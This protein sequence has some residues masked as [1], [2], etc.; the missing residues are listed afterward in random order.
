LWVQGPGRTIPFLLG[1]KA[2]VW[3]STPAPESLEKHADPVGG[4]PQ[5]FPRRAGPS[6]GCA[7]KERWDGALH[8]RRRLRSDTPHSL[9]PLFFKASRDPG[10]ERSHRESDHLPNRQLRVPGELL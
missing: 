10:T 6:Q 5:C 9:E 1:L 3:L 8:D 2:R 7:T 4:Q